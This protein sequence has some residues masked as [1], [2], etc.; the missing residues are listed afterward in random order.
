M[1]VEFVA[2]A[3]AGGNPTTG[4]SIT[5]P[6][7][8]I[9]LGDLMIVE[10]THRGTGDGS[11]SDN[12][13]DGVAWQRKG[14]VLFASNAFSVQQYYKR[15]T[16]AFVGTSRT[17]SGSGLT[18]SCAPVLTVYRGAVASGDPFEAW[19]AESNASGNESHG[20]ITTLTDG[21]FVCL[22]VGNSPDLAISGQACTSPGALTERAE[23]L[24]TGGTDASIAHAS[25]GKAS[26]GAT[27]ALTW[28]QTNAA[29][30]SLAYAIA[31]AVAVTDDLGDADGISTGA[32]TAGTPGIGQAHVLAG[33]ALAAGAPALGAPDLAEDES[34]DAL[35]ADSLSS[36][37]PSLG[38]PSPGQQHALG[39]GGLVAGTVTLGAPAVAQIHALS[40]AA[41]TTGAPVTGSPAM[42]QTHALGGA[43]LSTGRPT[44][45]T[46]ALNGA[47]VT[48][49]SGPRTLT[50]G[51]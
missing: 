18:N 31:P 27:G 44:C 47:A 26:A 36:G 10:F 14:E 17:I 1:A 16:A 23:K 51:L 42:A 13:G 48:R 6:G 5:S 9:Q 39:A 20:E 7:A 3:L 50:I 24:S 46:P 15:A 21:A 29:S 45:G 2:S 8:S 11:I 35:A 32:P 37:A 38:T 19:S 40:G 12:S 43:A 41:V 33:T 49:R 34:G 4:F 22:V 28:T 25:A 30:G